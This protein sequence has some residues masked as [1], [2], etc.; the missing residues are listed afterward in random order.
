MATTLKATYKQFNGTDWDT[1][2]FKTSAGQ[3]GESS[4][5][6]FLRPSTHKVNGKSFMDGTTHQSITLYGSDILVNSDTT[7]TLD[8]RLD[9]KFNT[10]NV[11]DTN[12][13]STGQDLRG[14]CSD[15]TVVSSEVLY[16]L[17]NEYAH[18]DHTHSNYFSISD[19]L[20]TNDVQNA[21]DLHDVGYDTNVV[22]A[23]V[24]SEIL[25]GYALYDHSHDARYLKI[26]DYKVIFTGST[27]PSNP[28]SGD[29][30]IN[31]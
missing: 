13:I 10:Y 3:V 15:E 9:K 12:V 25:S 8:V 27:T 26:S 29:I 17:L 19:I 31:Y 23:L 20:T 2:Y 16:N 21:Q 11:L 18:K 22:S 5:L 6:V 1:V 24:L 28:K 4:S 7:D 14:E 30:W